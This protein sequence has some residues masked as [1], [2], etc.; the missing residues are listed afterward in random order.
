MTKA[1][2]QARIRYLNAL[3]SLAA[4]QLHLEE[5]MTAHQNDPANWGFVG[6]IG[7]FEEKLAELIED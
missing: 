6:D 5:L 2:E 3:D 4:I 1:Q 7:R